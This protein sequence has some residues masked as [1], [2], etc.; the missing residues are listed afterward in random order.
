M[1]EVLVTGGSGF[2][3]LHCIQQLLSLGFKVRCTVRSEKKELEVIKAMQHHSSNSDLLTIVFADLMNDEGW[4]D[5][6][7][8]CKY[9]LHIASPF[10]TQE[11]ANEDI[12][13]R[14]AVNGTIRLLNACTV[15]Q[16]E[17]VVLT[18]S[19]VAIGYGHAEPKIYDERDWTQYNDRSVTAYAKSKTLAEKTAWDFVQSLDEKRRFKLTVLN[20]AGVMGPML[21]DDIGTTNAE[22]LLLL[23]GKF[24]R[25]P[26]L[27]VGW[28]DVRDVA[29]A[30]ITAMTCAS[31]DNERI[32]L[33]KKEFWLVEIAEMFR[34]AGFVKPSVK[35]MPN[36]I[37]KILALFMKDLSGIANYVGQEVYA[38][39]DKAKGIFDWKFI[40]IEESAAETAH[41]LD[42][43]G[44][45]N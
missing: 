5:A 13:I 38:N 39:K 18:S 32:I 37:V 24:P 19:F 43:M 35:E 36:V 3:A 28:V 14:P 21:S 27:H 1:D 45:V 26:K 22:L 10:V 7:K 2:I 31:T 11:P 40:S 6:V 25:V 16:V 29:K 12:L 30:H 42:R 17:K 23:R 20:P 15:H 44:L 8:G 4:E 9:V 41:Q 34:K 33:C